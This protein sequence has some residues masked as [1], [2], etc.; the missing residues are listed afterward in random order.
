MA[1][2]PDAVIV[3]TK[4]W[5]ESK[6]IW[7]NV[8]GGIIEILSATEFMNIIPQAWAS[9]IALAIFIG[10]LILRLIST[11]PIGIAATRLNE[12]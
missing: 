5:W 11:S 8:I 2:N 3:D 10:N 12:K 9:Y 6:T 1:H 7:L 4:H